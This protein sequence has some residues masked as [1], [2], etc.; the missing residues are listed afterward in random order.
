MKALL[1]TAF[2]PIETLSVLEAPS[3]RPGP[4]QVLLDVKAASLNFPDILMVQGLYQVKPPLPF[5]PGVEMSGVIVEAGREVKGFRPGDK[6]IAFAGWGGFAEECAVDAERLTPLPGGM[7]FV[8]GAAFLYTHATSLHALKDRGGLRAGET[9]LVLGAAGG[10]GLAAVE[11][12]KCMG[13][14]VIAA[15]SS[16]AKLD[17]CRRK[18]ADETVNYATG[19]LRERIRE[20]TGDTGV[21]VVYDPVGG[22]YTEAALRASAWRGRL[23][24]VGFAAGGIPKIPANL[25]LL[26]ERSIVG[27]YWGESVRRD[28]ESHLRNSRQLM[29]W[30]SAGKV[31]S[32]VSERVPLREAPAAMKRMA[33][34][35]VRGKIVIL[36]ES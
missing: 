17:L 32:A 14:R 28:P 18:G 10:V 22:P 1:C 3:P 16:E 11:I 6:V 9:L 34:R 31:T 33:G 24:V 19:N 12:G 29:E 4:S 13:A 15:A 8:T 30:F 2:G 5:S 7:D 36:P 20:I 27:V 26:K 35:E 25:A 21:D 23:L